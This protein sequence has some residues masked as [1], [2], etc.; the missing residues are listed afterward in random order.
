MD[1]FWTFLKWHQIDSL[2]DYVVWSQIAVKD[3]SWG[4][5][6]WKQM[7]CTWLCMKFIS[8]SPSFREKRPAV[9]CQLWQLWWNL[10][11]SDGQLHA[12]HYILTPCTLCPECGGIYVPSEWHV[13]YTLCR[14]SSYAEA[15]YTMPGDIY[16]FLRPSA[17]FYL[18]AIA[19]YRMPHSRHICLILR[20]WHFYNAVF[21]SEHRLP[22]HLVRH[23]HISQVWNI[24][25]NLHTV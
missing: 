17:T 18:S 5:N 21:A 2:L 23:Y 13:C 1:N 4:V 19:I 3:M 12:F 6:S 16:V 11:P 7:D 22:L 25:S 15:I 8:N 24:L 14:G 10:V 9:C 20:C